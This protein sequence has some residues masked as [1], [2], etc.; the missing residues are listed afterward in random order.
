MP[1]IDR[2]ENTRHIAPLVLAGAKAEPIVE[3]SKATI[4]TA[5]VVFAKR[6]DRR[7]HS[8]SAEE[9]AV[10]PQRLDKPRRGFWRT[11]Q[12]R[13]EC[14]AIRA[15]QHHALMLVEHAPRTLICEVASCEASHRHRL[16]NEPFGRG[17]DPQLEPL[18]L[19]LPLWRRR[20]LLHQPHLH[21]LASRLVR[22]FTVHGK[23]PARHS[24]AIAKR[25][26]PI[27]PKD[28]G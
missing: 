7:D 18:G 21:S 13:Q 22:H 5:S 11:V 8:R 26:A 14:V 10:T 1:I 15:G 4:E 20:F 17:G 6:L 25:L 12:R 2:N 23:R 28:R 16:L 9:T 19:V 24:N 27:R 3:Y